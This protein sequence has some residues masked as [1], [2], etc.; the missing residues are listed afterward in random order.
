[1]TVNSFTSVS[2]TPP[3]VMV[4]LERKTRTFSLV[5]RVK[6]FGV[7]ILSESQQEVSDCFAGRCPDHVDRFEGLETFTLQTGA[8]FIRSGLAFIDCQVVSTYDAGTHCLFIGEVVAIQNSLL[9][10]PL[11]YYNRTYRRMQ[12]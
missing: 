12:K 5:S 9:D 6:N 4:S 1:M 7:T 10:Q 8:P 3:L 2:L 11:L